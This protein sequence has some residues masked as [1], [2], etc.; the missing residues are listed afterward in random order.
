MPAAVRGYLRR[1]T[2]LPAEVGDDVVAARI[3]AGVAREVEPGQAV[4]AHG[5]EQPQGGPA[6]PPR[7]GR[8]SG[9]FED[10]EPAVLL[11]EEVADGEAGLAAADDDDLTVLHTGDR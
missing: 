11:G 4:V 8:L 3:A 7:G 1:A 5:R 9:R 2:L 6:A 10:G